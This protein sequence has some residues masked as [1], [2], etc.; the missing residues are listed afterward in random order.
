M[1]KVLMLIP[2]LLTGCMTNTKQGDVNYSQVGPI[3]VKVDLQQQGKSTRI[4]IHNEVIDFNFGS[5]IMINHG[6]CKVSSSTVNVAP[7]SEVI[8]ETDCEFHKVSTVQM[9][10]KGGD[11]EIKFI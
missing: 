11:I 1:K 5:R 2:F 10:T 9:F 4:R 7:Q 8:L 3:P 6:A